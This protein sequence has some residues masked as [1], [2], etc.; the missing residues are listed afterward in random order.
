MQRQRVL[1]RCSTV[2][3]VAGLTL[4]T[5][6]GTLDTARAQN[7]REA[8]R[9][10]F[11]ASRPAG[12]PMLAIVSLSEQRVTVYDA[13]GKISQAPVS[14]GATGYETPAGIYSIVQ[15]KPLHQSNLYEDGT[16]P[17]MMRITWTG[18]ALH[19]GALP[20]HPASHGCVRLPESF[21]QR[22]FDM[23]E[24]GMRVIVVREDIAPA[25]IAHPILFRPKPWRRQAA[26]M[27]LPDRLSGSPRLSVRSRE[28]PPYRGDVAAL[29]G[30][31]QLEVLMSIAA[32]KRAEADAASKKAGAAKQA[33]ARRAAEAAPAAKV[34]RAAEHQHARAEELLKRSQRQL[35]SAASPESIADVE[36]TKAKAVAKL[37]EARTQLDAANAQAQAKSDAATRANDEATAAETA[38]DVAIEAADEA[39]KKTLP[40]SVFVSRK[41]QRLYVRRG[42]EPVFEGPVMIIDADKPI[43]TYVFTALNSANDDGKTRWSVVSMYKGSDHPAPAERQHQHTQLRK[44]E[45]APANVMG[46]K[47][48]L[49]RIAIA[50][51]V[52]DQVSEVVLSGSS[53]IVSDEGPSIETGK[54]TGFV[55]ILS[56]EPQGGIKA[57]RREPVG[58]PRDNELFGRSPFRGFP[59]WK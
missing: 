27:T 52:I 39:Q 33:A 40:V 14:T 55:V 22:L 19:A 15:K 1:D 46:A 57:R 23:T 2:G 44:S 49:D 58:R 36:A 28:V 32:A 25:E 16:M 17:F 35:E 30:S 37:S 31:G 12:R 45:P 11:H 47:A 41:M 29:H 54:D 59:F 50:Q 26:A 42:F 53:L 8:Q 20:G 3:V 13:A 21:A 10:E 38:R 56:G 48:A 18:I 9:Q 51:D 4:L 24:I 7:S 6:A 5:A 43:G 34:L